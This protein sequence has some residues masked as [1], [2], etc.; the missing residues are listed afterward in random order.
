MA[1]LSQKTRDA[2][3]DS[4]FAY[5]D[6]RGR[7]R[8]PVNDESHVRNA[9]ARFNQT[10]FEGEEARSRALTRLLRAAK[11][12]GIVPVGFMT[13]QLRPRAAR[14]A[15][16]PSGVV[17]F[18]L[19]DIEDSTGLLQRLGDRYAD[20]LA[21]VRRLLLA[22]VGAADGRE[23]DSRAD[24]LFAVFEQ[25][26]TALKAALAI[27]R[28]ARARTW[29][30]AVELRL[31]LGLHTGEPSLTETGYMGLAVHT[32]VRVCSAGHGGQILLSRA[33]RE[34]LGDP[35]AVGVGFGKLGLYQLHGLPAPEALFQVEVDDLPH[36]FPALRALLA[37]A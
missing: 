36:E 32:A 23:V 30:D 8:L 28:E 1:P 21:D 10:V 12:Y 11:R 17:T 16:L 18:L 31:R 3:P 26:P 24:E 2:L 13:G 14:M 4:A 34:A 29:P 27:Q 5:I 9:L 15:A 22:A 25:A 35:P 7:R 33:A 19:T 20:F 6:S 37:S